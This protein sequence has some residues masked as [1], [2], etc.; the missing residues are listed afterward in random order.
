M[1]I[2][3][4]FLLSKKGEAHGGED[5][6]VVTPH[7]AAVID[8]ATA[9][10]SY[11]FGGPTGGAIVADTLVK[12]VEQLDPQVDA[13]S[14]TRTFT[15]LVKEQVY[16]RFGINP[17]PGEDRPCANMVVYSLNRREIWRIGDCNFSI[18]SEVNYGGKLI[19]NQNAAHR[20]A[21]NRAFLAGGGTLEQLATDDIG[22][23]AITSSL[24]T[25]AMLMN[26]PAAGRYAFGAIDNRDVPTQFIETCPVPQG[27][28]IVLASDGYPQILPTLAESEAYLVT[29]L[30]ADPQRIGKH[31]STKGL[32][33]GHVSFDDRAWLRLKI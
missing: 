13:Y 26:N 22:R 16:D 11:N 27:A 21:I 14:A 3:E 23:K 5:R 30:K 10:K 2:I 4:R 28:T 32:A 29:D 6:I 17:A 33:Q 1:Q 24:E 20:A 12:A 18:G 7:F 15:K 31:P 9:K 19:D 25:Q 8:G